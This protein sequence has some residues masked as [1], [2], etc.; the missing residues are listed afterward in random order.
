MGITLGEVTSLNITAGELTDDDVNWI[1]V[2]LTGIEELNISE[3]AYFTTEAD[4]VT[5]ILPD[6]AFG[7]TNLVSVNIDIDNKYKLNF[8]N[9]ALYDCQMLFHLKSKHFMSSLH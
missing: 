8:G 1:K 2:N 7:L 3:N 6:N 4:G 9:H 5:S